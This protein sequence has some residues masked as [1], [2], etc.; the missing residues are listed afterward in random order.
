MAAALKSYF[1]LPLTRIGARSL[2]TTYVFLKKD[3]KRSG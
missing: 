1:L 3:F 2:S